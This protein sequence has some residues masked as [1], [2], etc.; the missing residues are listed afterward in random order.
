VCFKK[1]KDPVKS[2][3]FIERGGGKAVCEGGGP[4][5]RV[6]G[7][8]VISPAKPWFGGKKWELS[9]TSFW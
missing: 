6:L 8:S 7:K 1:K 9:S 2:P 3:N 4:S 5:V